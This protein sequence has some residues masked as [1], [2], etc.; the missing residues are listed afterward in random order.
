MSNTKISQLSSAA[1]LDGTE[2]VPIVQSGETV[3]TTTQD[4]ADLGGGGSGYSVATV[5]LTDAQIKA[6]P[7][8][9]VEIIPAPGNNKAIILIS[10]FFQSDFTNGI[11]TGAQDSSWILRSGSTYISNPL[12]SELALITAG[13]RQGTFLIPLA[14]D[15]S[16]SFVGNLLSVQTLDANNLPVSIKDDF[17]GIP[18]YQGGDAANTLK[19]TVYYV[20]I[21]L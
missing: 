7:T 10:G 14:L 20:T 11:Y 8:T 18:N 4:I 5:T 6:L 21:D 12:S 17:A 19:I 13:K 2:E 1:A 15:G 3:K 16:G 9:A